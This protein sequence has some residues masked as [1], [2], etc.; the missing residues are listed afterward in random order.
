MQDRQSDHFHG[1][2]RVGENG[3]ADSRSR[4]DG[5]SR[6]DDSSRGFGPLEDPAMAKRFGNLAGKFAVAGAMAFA[7]SLLRP[8]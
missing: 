4:S 1:A 6:T 2:R 7:Y 3:G 5:S 8:G